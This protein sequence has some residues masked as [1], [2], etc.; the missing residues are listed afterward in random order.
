MQVPFPVFNTPDTGVPLPYPIQLTRP[1]DPATAVVFQTQKSDRNKKMVR[2]EGGAWYNNWDDFKRQFTDPNSGLRSGRFFN[3]VQGIVDPL[4]MFAERIGDRRGMPDVN[5]YAQ[6][7]RQGLGTFRRFTGLGKP[8]GHY[9]GGYMGGASPKSKRL[10]GEAAGP[11]LVG[12]TSARKAAKLMEAA[13]AAANEDVGPMPTRP[14][15]GPPKQRRSAGVGPS[16]RLRP[17][18]LRMPAIQAAV[19]AAASALPPQLRGAPSASRSALSQSRALSGELGPLPQSPFALR[20][21]SG[22]RHSARSATRAAV[23]ARSPTTL[24]QAIEQFQLQHTVGRQADVARATQ[25]LTEATLAESA[26]QSMR[27]YE[28]LR[29]TG[30]VAAAQRAALAQSLT[31]SQPLPDPLLQQM[32]YQSLMPQSSTRPR[33]DDLAQAVTFQD[34]VNDVESA[35]DRAPADAFFPVLAEARRPTYAGPAYI[36]PDAMVP[37]GVLPG[38]STGFLPPQIPSAP[39]IVAPNIMD[40]RFITPAVKPRSAASRRPSVKS[41]VKNLAAALSAAKSAR[42]DWTGSTARSALRRAKGMVL[43]HTG[44]LPGGIPD[45]PR[46]IARKTSG[47]PPSAKQ[48]AARAK[49]AEPGGPMDRWQEFRQMHPGVGPKELSALWHAAGLS[50]REN[51]PLPRRA[52]HAGEALRYARLVDAAKKQ[53]VPFVWHSSRVKPGVQAHSR[54]S[55]LTFL[56]RPYGEQFMHEGALHGSG[57]V[58]G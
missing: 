46:Q 20:T 55:D 8:R 15:P 48:L 42:S 1:Y 58:Y 45:I 31:R 12:K 21:S 2:M 49:F 5:R 56:G 40:M 3:T 54:L 4:T 44:Y 30:V 27:P 51:P 24:N 16:L 41:T 35:V 25:A 6:L 10:R 7:I 53:K 11:A 36:P 14:A 13:M 17:G 19:D 47:K 38:I 9:L 52:S 22:L 37:T 28:S 26:R 29:S 39:Q 50:T 32:P 23:L 43:R 18:A 34:D 33:A 57:R